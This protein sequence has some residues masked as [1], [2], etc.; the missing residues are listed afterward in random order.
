MIR[1]CGKKIKFGAV[2]AH[3]Y[4]RN[5]TMICPSSYSIVQKRNESNNQSLKFIVLGFVF[6]N[7][8]HIMQVNLEVII[9]DAI[10]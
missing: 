3:A 8:V 5:I 2:I 6:C 4:Y 7:I 10:R 1:P 9:Y